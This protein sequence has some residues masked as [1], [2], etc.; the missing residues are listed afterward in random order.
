MVLFR[1]R[2]SRYLLGWIPETRCP[3]SSQLLEDKGEDEMT[4]FSLWHHPVSSFL[5]LSKRCHRPQNLYCLPLEITTWVWSSQLSQRLESVDHQIMDKAPNIRVHKSENSSP[6]R[7]GL[8][9]SKN[10]LKVWYIREVCGFSIRT[11]YPR[12]GQQSVLMEKNQ[13]ETVPESYQS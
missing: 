6:E 10:Y 4:L 7:Q 9:S 12:Q 1:P 11:M 5:G 2:Q 3:R 8:H 13:E